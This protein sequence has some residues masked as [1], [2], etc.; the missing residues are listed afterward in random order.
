MRYVV[1]AALL[2]AACKQPQD[3]LPVGVGGGTAPG[4]GGGS[5]PDAPGDTRDG[6]G[7]AGRVCLAADPRDLVTCATT[8]AD[9]ITVTLGSAMATTAVD[10]SFTIDALDGTGLVW[11]ASSTAIATSVM[12]FGTVALIPALATTTYNDLL[13][14]VPLSPGEGSIFVRVLQNGTPLVGATATTS[15]A[16][17][18]PTHYETSSSLDWSG[19]ATGAHGVAWI[20]GQPVGAA[21]VSVTPSGGTATTFTVSVEDSA[22]TF[23]TTEVP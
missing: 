15:P 21:S 8:G 16:A 19:N 1:A 9:G 22:I 18:Y 17:Q 10:G 11:H 12:A 4:G 3:N 6:A 23:A 7:I 5:H 20:P 14:S 13:T 2:V